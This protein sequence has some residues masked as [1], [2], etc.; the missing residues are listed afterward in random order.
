MNS[1]ASLR[2]FVK[3]NLFEQS[4]IILIENLRNKMH[5]NLKFDFEISD[6]KIKANN[7]SGQIS[8]EL[9]Q[10]IYG[11]VNFNVIPTK[12]LFLENRK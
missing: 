5:E 8:F 9:S 12:V 1:W 2:G 11:A 7:I 10:G 4:E 3:E 6:V